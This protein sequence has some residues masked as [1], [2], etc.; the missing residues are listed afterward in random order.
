MRRSGM[1]FKDI[2]LRFGVSDQRGRQLALEGELLADP[3]CYR[4]SPY[5]LRVLRGGAKNV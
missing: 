3:A 4:H 1:T 2:G 5:V